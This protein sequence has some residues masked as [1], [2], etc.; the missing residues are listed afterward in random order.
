[1]FLTHKKS[2]WI[3]HIYMTY[4]VPYLIGNTV[5]MVHVVT[6]RYAIPIQRETSTCLLHFGQTL[7]ANLPSARLKVADP[8][9]FL[10]AQISKQR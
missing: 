9:H 3:P 1:M 4:N 7:L 6:N 10:S 2:G 8:R 5:V